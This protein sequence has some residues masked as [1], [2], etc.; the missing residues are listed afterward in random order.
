MS[1]FDDFVGKARQAA[2]GAGKKAGEIVEL[3]RLKISISQIRSDIDRLYQK[4][5]QAVYQIRG[6][7][8]DNEAYIQDLCEKLDAR[9]G[10][11]KEAEDKLASLKRSAPCPFC[12]SENS[13]QSVYCSQCGARLHQED[14]AATE[15]TPIG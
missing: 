4:L 12:G 2:D 10:D 9:H 14:D 3:S 15:E 1:Q 11:L 5:G 13:N 8:C 7:D 6:T